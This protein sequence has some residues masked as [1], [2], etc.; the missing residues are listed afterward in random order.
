MREGEG[1]LHEHARAFA[2]LG[3]Q[4]D[5]PTHQLD[6]LLADGHAQPDARVLGR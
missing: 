2:Q 5:A 3:V 1:E 6:E 4:P